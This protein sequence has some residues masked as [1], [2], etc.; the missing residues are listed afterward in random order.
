MGLSTIF[1]IIGSIAIGGIVLFLVINMNGNM[2]QTTY[3]DAQDYLVQSNLTTLVSIIEKDMRRIGYCAIPDSFPHTNEPFLAAGAH[4]ITFLA[5]LDDNGKMDTI[6]YS[7]GSTSDLSWSPN[8]NDF[9]FIRK[10]GS[11]KADTLAV[12]LTQFDC[13]FYDTFGT[14]LTFPIIVDSLG[15]CALSGIFPIQIT[16]M[17][18]N[19]Y[20]YNNQ[21][22]YAY[23]RQLRMTARNLY[24]R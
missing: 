13:N 7:V 15:G 5:D 22:T 3:T 1:D 9:P 18:Q 2:T 8:P 6:V 10:V 23:W 19:P 16:I 17:V 12:G 21:Y 11:K 14:L 20:G 4:N 24:N